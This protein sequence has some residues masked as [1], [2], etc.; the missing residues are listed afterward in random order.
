MKEVGFKELVLVRVVCTFIFQGSSDE[1]S[2]V[3]SIL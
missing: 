1:G 3:P 2:R